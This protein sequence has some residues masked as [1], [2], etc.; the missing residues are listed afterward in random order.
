[1][2]DSDWN[3]ISL[4]TRITKARHISYLLVMARAMSVTYLCVG[5]E[6]SLDTN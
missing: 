4:E 1:M 6:N 2:R 3:L 5:A